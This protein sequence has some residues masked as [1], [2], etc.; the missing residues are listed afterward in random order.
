M[1]NL[2]NL[3]SFVK[4][5]PRQSFPLIRYILMHLCGYLYL[6]INHSLYDTVS[7]AVI[8]LTVTTAER[9]ALLVASPPSVS[10]GIIILYIVSYNVNGSTNIMTR[11]FTTINQHLNDSV[12]SLLPFTNYVF[13]VRACTTAGCGPASD[14]VTAITLED[15][16][17]A[18]YIY[19][20]IYCC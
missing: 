20:D 13:T 7:E 15:G 2:A 16:K 9:S 1:E 12:E 6:H 11:N 17:I 3:W 19:I 10:N 4:V 18:V 14:N 8:D 5:S